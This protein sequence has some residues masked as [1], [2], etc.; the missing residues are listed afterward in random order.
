MTI[1]PWRTLVPFAAVGGGAATTLPHR[2]G[3]LFEEST[4]P[5][6][7]AGGGLLV[8]LRGGVS[9]RIDARQLL[10]FTEDELWEVVTVT[11]GLML[12]F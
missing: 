9:L 3:S 8:S 2:E 1:G 6:L 4:R 5:M 7:S 10:A 11:G 12:A